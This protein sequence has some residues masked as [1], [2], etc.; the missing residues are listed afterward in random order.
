MIDINRLINAS[1]YLVLLITLALLCWCCKMTSLYSLSLFLLFIAFRFSIESYL[2]VRD[3]SLESWRSSA[4]SFLNDLHPGRNLGNCGGR[5]WYFLPHNMF[6]YWFG[7]GSFLGGDVASYF[8]F[9]FFLGMRFSGVTLSSVTS[10]KTDI[11][12]QK[13]STIIPFGAG[14]LDWLIKFGALVTFCVLIDYLG[15]F[16]EKKMT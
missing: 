2:S 11:S 12:V 10:E 8:I 7:I 14:G 4:T 9:L 6:I 13:M 15:H 16:R 1:Y 3:V 5:L